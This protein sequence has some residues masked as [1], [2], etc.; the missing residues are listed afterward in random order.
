MVGHGGVKNV[1]STDSPSK[2]LH[3]PQGDLLKV[4]YYSLTVIIVTITRTRSSLYLRN[5]APSQYGS[6]QCELSFSAGHSMLTY[7]VQ[8]TL[9][10]GAS[11]EELEK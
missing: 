1:S 4:H 9:K 2:F 3:P 6:L 11:A 5:F 8:V 10:D 7:L